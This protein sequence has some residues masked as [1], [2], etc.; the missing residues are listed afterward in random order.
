VSLKELYA[1]NG[2]DGDNVRVEPAGA[3]YCDFGWNPVYCFYGLPHIIQNPD[4]RTC[5]SC[6]AKKE[7]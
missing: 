6:F 5:T 4:D 3:T 2:A 7:R 1:D